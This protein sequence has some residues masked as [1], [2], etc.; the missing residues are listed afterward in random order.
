MMDESILCLFDRQIEDFEN[1]LQDQLVNSQH[2]SKTK[3]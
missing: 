2:I 3:D 1:S